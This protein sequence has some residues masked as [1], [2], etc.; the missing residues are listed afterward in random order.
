MGKT[1]LRRNKEE[2]EHTSVASKGSPLYPIIFNVFMK[3]FEGQVSES[4]NVKPKYWFR[5]DDTFVN[6]SHGWGTARFL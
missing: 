3:D 6:S 2:E 1:S 5:Y 4:C